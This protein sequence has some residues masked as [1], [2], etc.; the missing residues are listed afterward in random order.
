MHNNN[1]R[2]FIVNRIEN[3]QEIHNFKISFDI[4]PIRERE[5]VAIATKRSIINTSIQLLVSVCILVSEKET[6][7]K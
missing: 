7:E 4:S 5:K 3:Q 2:M 1:Q 6:T